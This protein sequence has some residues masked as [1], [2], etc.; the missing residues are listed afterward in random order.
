VDR[1]C[2]DISGVIRPLLEGA[3]MSD[4][5]GD[6]RRP[7][8]E[9]DVALPTPFTPVYRCSKYTRKT[10]IL[11]IFRDLRR[12]LQAGMLARQHVTAS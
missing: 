3:E 11:A 1:G 12:G 2:R 9:V 10:A 4:D 7:V 8:T 6:C 5:G